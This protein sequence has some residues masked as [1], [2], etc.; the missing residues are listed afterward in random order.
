MTKALS[1]YRGQKDRLSGG[2]AL[3]QQELLLLLQP[4]AL[5]KRSTDWPSL[6]VWQQV[7]SMPACWSPKIAPTCRSSHQGWACKRGRWITMSGPSREPNTKKTSLYCIRCVSFSSLT[8]VAKLTSLTLVCII[9]EWWRPSN[10]TVHLRTGS[11]QT[12]IK[13]PRWC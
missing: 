9:N 10:I 4:V 2:S 11:I 6:S 12:L 7:K 3:L 8:N 5:F 13:L 1:C